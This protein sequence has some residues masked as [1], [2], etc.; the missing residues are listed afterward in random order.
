MIRR[1]PRSTLFPY[2][3]LFRSTRE[4]MR[5]PNIFRGITHPDDWAAQ[6]ELYQKLERGE[7][8]RFSIKKRYR[9]LDGREI[10]AEL[11]FRRVADAEGNYQEVSTL[12]DL[13]PLREA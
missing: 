4:Q 2:T 10:W 8:D 12:V 9:R 11:T 5:D 1:P 3:T 13:T 6:Q 7:T